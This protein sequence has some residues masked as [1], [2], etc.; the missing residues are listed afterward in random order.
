[1]SIAATLFALGS[2]LG[3]GLGGWISDVRGKKLTMLGSNLAASVCWVV[4]AFAGTKWLLFGSYSLQGFFGAIAY[5]CIGEANQDEIISA[6]TSLSSISKES[7]L[8]RQPM[9]HSGGSLD[10]FRQLQPA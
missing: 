9:H 1:M 7:S 4:T 5:N 10:H 8:L 3:F 2:A 6:V